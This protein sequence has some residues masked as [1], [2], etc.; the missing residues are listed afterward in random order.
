MLGELLWKGVEAGECSLGS[1]VRE[2]GAVGDNV[3]KCT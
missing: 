3:H 2:E 1:R